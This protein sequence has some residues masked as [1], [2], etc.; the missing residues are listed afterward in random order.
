MYIYINFACLNMK[1]SNKNLFKKICLFKNLQLGPYIYV[2]ITIFPRF[3][4]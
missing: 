4:I 1:M 2:Y 3:N